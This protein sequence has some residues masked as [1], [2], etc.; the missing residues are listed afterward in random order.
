MGMVMWVGW[1]EW[2]PPP[3]SKGNMG[4]I[5]VTGISLLIYVSVFY[6]CFDNC[7]INGFNGVRGLF[8]LLM[9]ILGV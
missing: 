2:A 5:C 9:F 7:I 3:S 1:M 6:L 4:V 8:R